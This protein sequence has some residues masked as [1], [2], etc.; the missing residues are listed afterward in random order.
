MTFSNETKEQILTAQNHF[1]AG[2]GCHRPVHSIHH[3]LSNCKANR[4]NYPLLI[5]SVINGVGLCN[6]C[7]TN[8]SYFYKI[9]LQEAE[10]YESFLNKLKATGTTTGLEE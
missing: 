9:T 6:F 3:K 5:H 1:C 4:K 7:H 10:I 8:R 2:D